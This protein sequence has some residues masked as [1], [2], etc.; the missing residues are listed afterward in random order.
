MAYSFGDN[1]LIICHDTI[2]YNG[3]ILPNPPHFK[4][5]NHNVTTVDNRLYINGYEWK[6]GK[7][8][9]TF[10]ALWHLIF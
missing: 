10:A 9:R 2:R 6:N 4:S 5:N 8:K 3:K 7:W 1:G